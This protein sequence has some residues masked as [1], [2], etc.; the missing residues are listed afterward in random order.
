M[1]ILTSYDDGYQLYE[2][3]RSKFCINGPQYRGARMPD[4]VSRCINEASFA[5]ELR[6]KNCDIDAFPNEDGEIEIV[7]GWT[8][9]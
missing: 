6:C 2:E 9:Q 1:K 7:I 3:V 4:P 8:T 5:D